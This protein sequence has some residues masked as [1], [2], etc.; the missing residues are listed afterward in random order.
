[1]S[2][3]EYFYIGENYYVN[4]EYKKAIEYFERCNEIDK[5]YDCLNYIG[6]CYLG[7]K[8]YNTAI[9][10]FNLVIES[11]PNSARPVFNLGRAYLKLGD[12]NSALN[13]FHKAITINP[14]SEDAY[15]YL[16]VCY[17]KIGDLEKAKMNYEKSLEIDNQQSET[18]LNLGI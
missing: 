10:I 16:G 3:E 11:C 4:G 5:S 13:S 12:F 8:D 9:N 7:L 17:Q 14:N 1:L 2:F 15:Y 6:C 18:Y